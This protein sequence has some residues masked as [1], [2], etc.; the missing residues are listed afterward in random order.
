MLRQAKLSSYDSLDLV[1]RFIFDALNI[2]AYGLASKDI[3]FSGNN[4]H[5]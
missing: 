5:G 4:I 2:F 3:M 1:F